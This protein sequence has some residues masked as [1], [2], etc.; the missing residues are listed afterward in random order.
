MQRVAHVFTANPCL[1]NNGGCSQ[2]C[3]FTHVSHFC[4]CK[5]GYKLAEDGVTCDD[6][7]ECQIF[8]SCSQ[9][10]TNTKGSFKCSCLEGYAL[11]LHRPTVCRAI[12]LPSVVFA[13]RFDVRKINI[14]S[15]REYR[16]LVN[17]TRSS[18]AVDYDL[19]ENKLYYSDV[20]N[21]AIF[22]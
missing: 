2:T 6:I 22:S 10:C 15:G 9:L 20:A 1:I 12:V 19:R 7:D 18:V 3:T 16:S 13:N 4:D 5:P 11:D 21:E 8:G 17:E 14:A